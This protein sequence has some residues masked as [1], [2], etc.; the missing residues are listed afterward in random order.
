MLSRGFASQESK[1][2][3]A[4]AHELGKQI[5]NAEERFDTYYGLYV[6]QLMRSEL[7]SARE[8]AEAFR[9]EAESAGRIT[10]A[11]GANRNLGVACLFQGDLV[12]AQIH[13]SE[14]LR[15][16]H[17]ERD[18]DAKFRFGAD[19]S[20]AASYLAQAKWCSGETE[21]AFELIEQSSARAVDAGHAPTLALVYH[22]SGPIRTS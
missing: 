5:G 19:T 6:G 14:A 2:A 3:F 18:H 11:A 22:L 10:E 17:P 20:V 8:T 7:A 9:R 12:D 15:L 16:Y 1:V 21:R 4:R 13:L